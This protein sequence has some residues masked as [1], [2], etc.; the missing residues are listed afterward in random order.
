M[1]QVAVSATYSTFVSADY[2]PD[3]DGTTPTTLTFTAK[4]ANDAVITGGKVV[5]YA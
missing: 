3:S 1:G 4:D 5:T 2:N